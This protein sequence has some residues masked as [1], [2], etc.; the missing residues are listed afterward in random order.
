VT[1]LKEVNCSVA[2][3]QDRGKITALLRQM[4]A[5]GMFQMVV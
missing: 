2:A 1:R 4:Q 5:T 3:K